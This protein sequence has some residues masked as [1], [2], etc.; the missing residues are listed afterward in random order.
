MAGTARGENLFLDDGRM[1]E[2]AKQPKLLK[3]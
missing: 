1:E 3:A 2:N